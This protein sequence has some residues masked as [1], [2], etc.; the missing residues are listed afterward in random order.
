MNALKR[1]A[2]ELA[3]VEQLRAFEASAASQA[4]RAAGGRP[5]P[6]LREIRLAIAA[7]LE[8]GCT[9]TELNTTIQSLRFAGK[10]HWERLELAPSMLTNT[11]ESAGIPIPAPEGGAASSRAAVEAPPSTDTA[12][13]LSTAGGPEDG[14]EPGS[15]A[16]SS[17]PDD[18]DDYPGEVNDAAPV[19][20]FHPRSRRAAGGIH[21]ASSAGGS[22]PLPVPQHETEV[23]RAVREECD[24]G[25]KRRRQARSI[26][27]VN[28]PLEIRKFGVADM[29]IG[30]GI[31]SMLADTPHDLI[32]AIGRKH[33]QLW[34]R[35]ITLGRATGQRPAQALYAALERGLDQLEAELPPQPA[36][37]A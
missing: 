5:K 23:Q 11:I 19:D 26:G 33:P 36:Q 17:G 25:S 3:L 7:G 34:R 21:K 4:N 2:V 35:V 24:E 32:V 10:M 16:T 8:D 1:K 37:A 18:D 30:E 28:Q 22:R 14:G 12:G 29:G 20:G 6:N 9:P 13:A 31:A 27:G 15:A